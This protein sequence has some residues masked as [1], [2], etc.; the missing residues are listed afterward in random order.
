MMERR[1]EAY[2]THVVRP[3][4]RDHFARL[5]RQIV[6]VDALAALNSGPAALR[7]LQNALTR[8]SRAFRV[9]RALPDRLFRPKIDQ[10]LVAATKADHLH[11]HSHD[12]LEAILRQLTARAISRAEFSGAKVDVIALAAIRA[13]RE[14]AVRRGR[15]TLDAIVGTPLTGEKLDGQIFDGEPK[16]RSFPANCRPIREAFRGDGLASPE[17]EADYRFLRFRPPV[18]RG[19]GAC[20]AAYQARPRLPVPV[21][22]PAVMSDA[23]A[24][25]A[26]LPPR[27]RRVAA[28]RGAWSRARGACAREDPIQRRLGDRERSRRSKRRRQPGFWRG[29]R[30]SWGGLLA[31]RSAASSPL[32]SGFG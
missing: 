2:K 3:F 1:Y 14:A 32:P 13:T 23:P 30:F 10:I 5:D 22:R 4:F 25:P 28:A 29:S 8:C 19:D 16:R 7:D 9:G 26:R 6:L 11:H 20:R 18:D 31:P 24:P 12:R 17:G 27:R 21:R 15:E